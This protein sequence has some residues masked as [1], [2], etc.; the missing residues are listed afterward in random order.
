MIDLN[1]LER[2][3]TRINASDNSKISQLEQLAWLRVA[4]DEFA[5]LMDDSVGRLRAL[6]G[7]SWAEIGEALEMSKQG[8]QQRFGSRLDSAAGS[9]AR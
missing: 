8:A 5:N 9:S 4:Q 6:Y 2:A 1:R 3:L 7:A